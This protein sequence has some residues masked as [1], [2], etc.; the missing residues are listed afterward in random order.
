MGCIPTKSL[1]R[2]A[3]LANIVL[4]EADK[5]GI[6]GNISVDYGKAFHRSRDVADKSAKGVH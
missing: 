2:N 5:Y 6:S 1:L 4:R 3:E